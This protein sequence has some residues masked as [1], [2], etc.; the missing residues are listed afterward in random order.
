MKQPLLLETSWYREHF[1][2]KSRMALKFRSLLSCKARLS[3]LEAAFQAYHLAGQ[4]QTVEQQQVYGKM[5]QPVS[6]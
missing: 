3:R 4:L 2:I 5:P 1:R 6:S